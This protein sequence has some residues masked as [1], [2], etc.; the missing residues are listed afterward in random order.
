LKD[1]LQAFT[2][3]D[4]RVSALKRGQRDSNPPK[5]ENENSND[6]KN[7]NSDDDSEGEEVNQRLGESNPFRIDSFCFF[8]LSKVSIKSGIFIDTFKSPGATLGAE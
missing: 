7:I 6:F 5:E 2:A 8:N 4:R 1:A 3:I